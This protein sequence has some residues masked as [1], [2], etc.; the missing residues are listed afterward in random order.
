MIVIG[1]VIEIDEA[2]DDVVFETSFFDS[3][4]AQR[5]RFGPPSVEI[6]HPQLL[7]NWRVFQRSQ[8][9]CERFKARLHLALRHDENSRDA[10]RPK[11]DQIDRLSYDCRH[12][13]L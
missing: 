4:T 13:R 5:Y 6:L 7:G 8:F 12:I 11:C 10:D 1:Y 2:A 3:A 9:E